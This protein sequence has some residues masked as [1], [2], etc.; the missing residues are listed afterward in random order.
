MRTT[1]IWSSNH[2]SASITAR[3]PIIMDE[4]GCP[5]EEQPF[6]STTKVLQKLIAFWE[7]FIHEWAQIIGRGP[8]G[9][10]YFLDDKVLQWAN[11]NLG[12]PLPQTLLAALTYL[13]ALLAST[14]PSHSKK[15]K[16]SIK[17]IPLWDLPNAPRWRLIQN[18]DCTTIPDIPSP[19]TLDRAT[20]QHSIQSVL[21][22]HPR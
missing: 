10:P 6:P 22:R 3:N 4:D 19:L 2:I 1:E 16:R 7:H 9:C 8:D 18:E 11:P 20:R 15:L 21:T 14:D 12:T 17:T 13:R 5:A